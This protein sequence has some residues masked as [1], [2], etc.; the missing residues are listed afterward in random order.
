MPNGNMTATLMHTIGC[1][2]RIKLATQIANKQYKALSSTLEYRSNDSTTSL[3]LANPNILEQQGTLVFH[4]LQAITSRISLG[5]EMACL[6]GS[7][8]PGH[9]ETIM[10]FAFR[11]STG[12]KTLSATLGQ[13]GFHVCYHMKASH[14]LQLGVELETNMRTHESE[15]AFVYQVDLPYSNLIFRGLVNSERTVSA[16]IEKRLQP[17]ADSSLI[18][19]GLYNHKKEQFRVGVG[20]SVG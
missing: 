8:I 12:P 4:F 17:L 7:K 3:T 1:R 19:S 20:L 9:Q 16:V 15:G 13:A 18:I 11:Y 5:A 2:Y 10:S 6:R 14:Q